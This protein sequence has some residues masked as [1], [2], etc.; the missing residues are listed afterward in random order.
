[1][2]LLAELLLAELHDGDHLLGKRP[3]SAEALAEHQDLRDEREV[4]HHHAHGAQ[5]RLEVVG[6]LAAPRVARVHRHIDRACGD[7]P[8]VLA[9]EDEALAPLLDGLCVSRQA[10]GVCGVRQRSAPA[11]W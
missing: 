6:Q 11:G 1:M 4:G 2:V 5:Q 9:Q 8:D 7:E 3:G 10:C